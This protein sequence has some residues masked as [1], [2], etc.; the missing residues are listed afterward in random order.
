MN[1]NP[2]RECILEI[3]A[4]R[5]LTTISEVMAAIF[6]DGYRSEQL[7]VVGKTVNALERDGIVRSII[8][9]IGSIDSYIGY[10]VDTLFRMALL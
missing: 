3:I 9:K 5:G 8:L 2:T 6:P 7:L 10:E 4:L 1:L